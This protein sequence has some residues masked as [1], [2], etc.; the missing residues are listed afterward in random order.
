VYLL[1]DLDTS[2]FKPEE[3]ASL[4][5]A[6]DRGA[7]LM[8]IGGLY[9]FGPGGYAETPLADVLPIEMSRLER[10]PLEDAA[11][12]SD[13]HLPGP[14]RMRLPQRAGPPDYLVHLAKDNQALWD[15][16][17]PLDGAN[18]LGKLKPAAHLLAQT[19]SGQ[20]LLV[21]QESGNGRVLAF[22][23]DS[24][25]RWVMH[26]HADA[27][28]RFWRQVILWLARKDQSAT[29]DVWLKIDERRHHPG[30]RVEFA[31]GAR[32][33]QNEPI[34]DADFRAEVLLPD[35]SRRPATLVRQGQEFVGCRRAI[36]RSA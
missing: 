2:A 25:W 20:P 15:K 19:E 3:L 31:A 32:T 21:A 9:S 17:P 6:V 30:G 7:G 27:H 24:T 16:L 10:Q 12:R 28:K 5:L 22:A 14:L 11:I 35:G 29:G 36:T 34:I 4:T 8:M 1:G 18:R 13:L 26:G 33:A 23:G